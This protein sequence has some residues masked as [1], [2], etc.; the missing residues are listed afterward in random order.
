M[1]TPKQFIDRIKKAEPQP[2]YLFLG[3]ELFFRDRCRRALTQ[4]VLGDS[5][6]ETPNPE[7]LT[8]IDLGRQHLAALIDEARTMSLF[9]TARL[10][11]GAH[12]EA[13]IPRVTGAKA[14]E[15]FEALRSYAA[16]PTPGT[17]VLF[18][19]TR[20]DLGE[21]DDKPKIDRLVKLFGSACEIVEM[22]RL[23]ADQALR[24]SAA[25]AEQLG[26]QIDRSSLTDLVEMLG[27]DM[28]RL[29][30]ELEKLSL[31][32]GSDRPVQGEDLE[33]LIPEARRRGV[34]EF[35]D[36][37]AHGDRVR[38]L[39]ILD[40]LAETGVSWPMQVNLIAGLLRQ[41][42]AMKEQGART[43]QQVLSVSK[44]Y[45]IRMWPPR[46]RQLVEIGRHF[47]PGRLEK[48]LI[49]LGEAD[50]DLR[51]ERPNDRVIMEQLVM[52]L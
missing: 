1:I 21:R 6:T 2:V 5:A 37:L 28:G 32:V 39:D 20:F 47:S 44:Q 52:A 30:N 8:E 36:A 40:T 3:N 13:A 50:R 22:K 9:A 14:A 19:A 43:A 41:A 24:E 7:G 4:V 42:L 11:I 29:A 15:P 35:S 31:Y 49:R 34:F 45:G 10:L 51:R 17:V 12:A 25:R 33:L 26:L 27:G 23:S 38:A 16:S 48:A 46:V 18:E